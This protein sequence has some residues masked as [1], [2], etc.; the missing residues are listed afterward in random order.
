MTETEQTFTTI[1]KINGG[2]NSQMLRN[3]SFTDKRSFS[4]QN[5]SLYY[6]LK[7]IDFDGTPHYS[8]PIV[9]N[10]CQE[11]TLPFI[12][13]NPSNGKIFIKNISTAENYYYEIYN[14]IGVNLL[15]GF[16]T[17]KSTE[18][19]LSTFEKGFFYVTV[20]NQ[21]RSVQKKIIVQ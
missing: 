3:Y 21:F 18:I 20:S 13:P 17:E 8:K 16:L 10:N 15:F 11:S 14:A 7:Q 5:N 4:E 6:L 1:A 9:V 12:Y 19:D 2:G